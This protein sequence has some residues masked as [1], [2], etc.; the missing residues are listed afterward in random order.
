MK[1]TDYKSVYSIKFLIIV[2]YVLSSLN[3]SA[4]DASIAK[5]STEIIA[6]DGMDEFEVVPLRTPFKNAVSLPGTIE[7]EDFDVGGEGI[8]YHDNDPENKGGITYRNNGEG[9]DIVAGNGGKVVGWTSKGEWIEYTVNVVKAGKY[10]YEATVSSGE[11]NGGFS[12][13]LVGKGGN[14]INLANVDVPKTNNW[15]TYQ[16]VK[17]Y[18]QQSFV[19]GPQILRITYTKANCNVDKVKFIAVSEQSDTFEEIVEDVSNDGQSW[20]LVDKS[21]P[22]IGGDG[23]ATNLQYDTWSGRGDK[24][25]SNMTT[26]FME[27]HRNAGNSHTGS[28]CNMPAVQ[29]RHQTI[30]GLSKGKYKLSM[31]IRCYAEIYN[32]KNPPAGVKIYANGVESGDVCESVK[33]VDY[34]GGIHATSN[35]EL[36]FEVGDDG[37]LDFGINVTED[38]ASTELNWIAWKDIKIAYQRRGVLHTLEPGEYYVRN[39][40]TGEWMQ[41]GGNWGTQLMLGQHGV[42]VTAIQTN[43]NIYKL[44]SEFTNPANGYN[45]LTPS[46]DNDC[47][48]VEAD[49]YDWTIEP[50]SNEGYFTIHSEYGYLGYSGSE[51]VDLYMD[52]PEDDAAQWEFVSR[53]TRL[54]ALAEGAETDATFLIADPRFDRNHNDQSEWHSDVKPLFGGINNSGYGNQCVEVWNNKFDVNQLLT[55]IPNGRYQ[56]KA[57]GY[58]RFNDNGENNNNRAIEEYRNGNDDVLYA[59]LYMVSGGIT[60]SIS[61]PSVASGTGNPMSMEAAGNAFLNGE[62]M[63]DAITIDVTNHKLAIGVKKDSHPGCDWTIWDNFELTLLS[64][65]DNSD[66]KMDEDTPETDDIAWD[67][68][69]PDNPVDCTSLI[70]NPSFDRKSGWQGNPSLAGNDNRIVSY[71]GRGVANVTFNVYQTLDNLRNGIYRLKMKGF[72]RY[73]D[74][75]HEEHKSYGGQNENNDNNAYATYTIP[76]ATLSHRYGIERQ[77][78]TL[79]ANTTSVGLPLIFTGA[80]EM[81]TYSGDYET[82]FGWVPNSTTGASEALVGDDYEVELL[83]PVTDGSIQFGIRKD[84]GYKYDWT[85][86]DDFRLEYLGSEGLVYVQ[87]IKPSVET[88]TLNLYEKKQLNV[89]V[90]PADASIQA[91]Q[92]GTDGEKY[93]SVDNTGLVTAK[94]PGT[95][96]IKVFTRGSN[97]E[98]GIVYTSIPFTVKDNGSSDPSKLVINEIQVSNLDMFPDKSNNYGGYI[99]LY[100]PTDKG[101]SLNGLY[102]SDESTNPYK[103]RLNSKN[104]NIPAKGFSVIFF[105]HSSG[106]EGNY[107][108][109]VN[110]KL[111]MDGGFIG[112]YRDGGLITSENYPDATSRVSY[113]RTTDGGSNWGVTAYPTPGASNS[114]SKEILPVKAERVSSPQA[115]QSGFYAMSGFKP[116][117]TGSENIYCT[118]DGTVPTEKSIPVE[119]LPAFDG[120]T[121]LRIRAFE[122][123]K[124]PSPVVTRT[125][126]QQKYNHTLPVLMVTAAPNDIYSD[127][128]GIFVTGTNGISGHGIEYPC[129]WTLDWDRSANMQLLSK[130]GENLFQQDVNLSRFGGW[131]RSWIPFNFKLK[132]QKQYEGNNYLEY[133]FFTDNKPYLKHKVLQ[134]RNGGNDVNCR[135]KDASLHNIILTSGFYLD[136]LD[137]QPVHCYINGQ[138]Y[139]MQNLREPSNKHYGLA[140]YGID[141]DE[142]DAMEMTW[143]IYVKA[144]SRDSFTQWE[145]LAKN[146]SDKNAYQQIC[147][148]VDVDEFANYMAAQAY[149]GGDDWP[150]NNCKGFKGNDGKFHIVFFDVDQALRFDRG[151]LDRIGSAGE[152]LMQIF[153]NMLDNDT[154]RKQFIDSFCLFGGSVMEPT[155]CHAII[156]RMS[157]EM[158]PALALEG[159]ST[160]PTADYMKQVLTTTRQQTMINSLRNWSYVQLSGVREYK[161]KLTSSIE[162][163]KLRVNGLPVPTNTFEGS[164]FA[165]TVIT[166]ALPEGYTFKGW[167]TDGGEWLLK[168]NPTLDLSVLADNE[169]LT[170]TLSIQAVYEEMSDAQRKADLAM[171][172]KVNEVSANNTVF[173]SETW[174]RSDWIELYNTTDT[175][176]D[177]AGLFLSDDADQPLK[178]QIEKNSAVCNTVIPAG[179]HLI[180]WA[181]GLGS[182]PTLN[183][184]HANFKLSNSN[185]QQVFL[186]SGD[187][188]V[189]NNSTYF[190][191][192]P[193][194]LRFV[195]GLSY[196]A[197]R[198]DETVGRYPDGG[199]DFYRM[200]RPTIER[201][202]TLLTSDE[203]TGEDENLMPLLGD[204]FILELAKGWNWV[205]H[206]LSVSIAPAEL[207][208]SATRVLSQTREAIRDGSKM[209]GTLKAMD[210]GSLYKVQ[211]K[212]S[213][214][215]TSS[216]P[217]CDYNLP[218]ALLPGWNW[219]GYPVD[220]AQTIKVA[221]GGFLA[222]E[223]DKLVGQDGFATYTSGAW[224]GSLSTFET[225]KGYMLYTQKAKSFSFNK[226]DVS[227]N[228]SRARLAKVHVANRYGVDK[229]AYPNVMGIIGQLVIEDEELAAEPD[230]FTLLAYNGEECRGIGTWMEGKIYM[231]AYGQGDEK[232]QFFALDEQDGT[233]WHV[234]EEHDFVADIKGA[235]QTPCLFHLGGCEPT[236]IVG[237]V[238]G[239]A[240]HMSVEGYYNLSGQRMGNHD[241]SLTSGIYVVKYADGSFRKIY[242]K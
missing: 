137:Y 25:G 140:D 171:P 60:Q 221:L 151:S 4:Y 176:I 194:M 55:S 24:D 54:K 109:N 236:D 99:E 34:N 203:K 139:G 21:N 228:L 201:A 82:E 167:K 128:M 29:I 145:N 125:Y 132:A 209:V 187:A 96:Y 146:A 154:F 211:M 196:P 206:N 127:E 150:G 102:I 185:E 70:K 122:E 3:V 107:E 52:N 143:G 189:K 40:A 91:L 45:H 193:E 220:G 181:D 170:E 105:D 218:I 212:T 19:E 148:I 179:G 161:L 177:V 214:T 190:D 157:A 49:E 156:D 17:G 95:G 108:G 50:A 208:Q 69:T 83:V 115:T 27:F 98:T 133:P 79:Y 46:P 226:P 237:T 168:N 10:T 129:N 92:W 166:A 131:S 84:R 71:G 235:E 230:R 36:S 48:Y 182:E 227:V 111:D 90:I 147:N 138:Y 116:I 242:I 63:T 210:A 180:V 219:I 217:R 113:A 124:L 184:L 97:N 59:K 47:A 44:T 215:F 114:G 118:I 89:S 33:F 101:I 141:T 120:T 119:E 75:Q 53:T 169:A 134:V 199:R 205:S 67:E 200:G 112:I 93:V 188:F 80:K 42:L 18:L 7:A 229:Y 43:E 16:T 20:Y 12:I 160:S 76:Y 231:T 78:A 51:G 142:M 100:N 73:G 162:A 77:F 130:D 225:G 149:L 39:K 41:A 216:L 240:P 233:M 172:I 30:K 22:V 123:G 56:L 68:A 174:K 241:M 224:K 164:L 106:E 191:Q 62:Y 222:E 15:D 178:F 86:F 152:P 23:V 72:Y 126:V 173:V 202:N 207:P 32:G 6:K 136:V 144:G 2:S 192:H 37:I 232:L 74:V 58:Y 28:Q 5:R 155:R 94:A 121:V 198:G 117:I 13:S 195:D 85:V 26:P 135:I 88:F 87:E 159:L 110:F 31:L 66:Y 175:D 1:E 153:K 64:I 11:G 186:V 103:H 197:H 213:G 234:A 204:D 38:A 61:L 163:G 183:Q 8:T 165:P 104:D 158:N 223:G 14:L 238:N 9:V 239:S 35:P 65:G 81:A 57:Q